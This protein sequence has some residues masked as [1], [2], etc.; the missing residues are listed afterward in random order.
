MARH[1]K[2]FHNASYRIGAKSGGKISN[3]YKVLTDLTASDTLLLQFYEL[4][5]T[6]DTERKYLK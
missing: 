4:H 3:F 1:R 2:L 6:T 5:D